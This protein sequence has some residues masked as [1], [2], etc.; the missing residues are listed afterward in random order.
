VRGPL[1][2]VDGAWARAPPS[3]PEGR[4]DITRHPGPPAA[5]V[6]VVPRQGPAPMEY[7]IGRKAA[8]GAG[9]DDQA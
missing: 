9:Q 3:R 1:T 8:T 5:A 6:R 7:V 4:H 2:P